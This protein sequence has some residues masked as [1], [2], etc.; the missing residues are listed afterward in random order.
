[1]PG[2]GRSQAGLGVLDFEPVPVT[3]TAPQGTVYIP[4]R[5]L[6]IPERQ[7][8]VTIPVTNG[9]AGTGQPQAGMHI[10][11]TPGTHLELEPLAGPDTGEEQARIN[12]PGDAHRAPPSAVAE[13]PA[14]AASTNSGTNAGH[15]FALPGGNRSNPYHR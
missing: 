6:R 7:P 5:T 12:Q 15:M 8:H 13:S 11:A 10:T 4:R 14:N 2:R 9:R 1:M 3:H